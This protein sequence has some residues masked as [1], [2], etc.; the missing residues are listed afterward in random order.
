MLGGINNALFF[1]SLSGFA[2]VALFTVLLRWAFARG[3]SVVAAPAVAGEVDDYGL[4]TVVATPGNHIEGEMW[5]QHLIA[6]GIKAN[7]SQTLA[8]PQLFVFTTEFK[9]AQAVLAAFRAGN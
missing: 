5:R 4:L 8:G 7:L 3:K 9:V 1:T 2:V 6:Q